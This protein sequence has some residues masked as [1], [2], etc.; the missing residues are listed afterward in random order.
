MMD[1]KSKKSSIV[2]GIFLIFVGIALL[3]NNLEIIPRLLPEYIFSWKTLLVALGLI[4]ALTEKDKTPGIVLAAIGFYFLIPDI[5]NINPSEAGLFWP[6]LF[7]AVG[8]SILL[9]RK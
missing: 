8:L 7:V 6:I 4:F 9:S 1:R 2:F 3:L 5:W